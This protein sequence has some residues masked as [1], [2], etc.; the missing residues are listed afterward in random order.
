MQ[1]P[2]KIQANGELSLQKQIFEQIRKLI[3]EGSLLPGA[4]LPASRE[5]KSQLKVSRNTINFV[6]EQLHAEGYI[7]M[8]QGAGTFVNTNIPENSVMDRA[9]FAI[10]KQTSQ[11][12]EE[13][14]STNFT[15]NRPTLFYEDDDKLEIDFRVGKPDPSLFPINTWRKIASRNLVKTNHQLTSYNDPAGLILLRQQLSR[16]LRISRGIRAEPE[17]ILI[18]AGV[19]EALNLISRVLI[20][21]E[22]VVAMESP[23]YQGAA[24]TF[25]SYGAKLSPIPVDESGIQVPHLPDSKIAL[26]YVT[27]SNQFPLGHT[28][29]L[30]RRLRLIEWAGRNNSYIVED[31]YDSDFRYASSPLT[32]LQGLDD[33]QRVIYTSTFSKSLGAG[34]RLAYVIIPQHLLEPVLTAKAL[35]NNGHPWLD[36]MILTEF[37]SSGGFDNHLRKV[38]KACLSRR[39]ALVSAIT[40]YF[41]DSNFSGLEGGMHLV[42]YLPED[43]PDADS[44]QKLA[45]NN[46]IGIY[47]LTLGHAHDFG[48][49]KDA[50]RIILLGY[51]ALTENEIYEG[52]SRIRALLP[53]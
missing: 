40:E 4:R 37:L 8:R 1:L 31:D 11:I 20:E 13:N 6:Y 2:L 27:P 39:N 51:A 32:A 46:G 26:V 44:L 42:W 34:I 33:Y 14:Y 36:Q 50:N 49:G 7:E 19:Q 53:V 16:H 22:S 30:E 23:G 48:N 38:R 18:V 28:M 29:S 3:L 12:F 35:L 43:L 52:I 17:Q 21:R 47:S 25:Q 24:F 10:D 5:L 41:P 9:N 45:R 15:A